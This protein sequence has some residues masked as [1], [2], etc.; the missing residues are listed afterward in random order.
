MILKKIPKEEFQGL[1]WKCLEIL[2]ELYDRKFV[3]ENHPK[4]NNVTKQY[5]KLSN[6]LDTFLAENTKEDLNAYIPVSKFS[7]KYRAYLRKEGLRVWTPNEIGRTM[8]EK[9][10]ERAF[11]QKTLPTIRKGGSRTTYR[12]WY[13]IK[14]NAK[15]K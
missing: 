2:K 14:W 9:G 5:E 10:K 1:T 4:T 7:E 15:L 3:F 8:K 12:V 11:K 6:P 13:G